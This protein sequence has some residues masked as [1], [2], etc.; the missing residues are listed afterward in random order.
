MITFTC[1]QCQTPLTIPDHAAGKTTVCPKCQQPVQIPAAPPAPLP[2]APLPV[3]NRQRTALFVLWLALGI[4]CAVALLLGIV[5]GLA[6][7]S[8][9][10]FVSEAEA[11]QTL[12]TIRH[13]RDL[14]FLSLVVLAGY[15]ALRAVERMMTQ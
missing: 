7:G 1:T 14:L 4:V 2:L 6:G 13:I 10:G 5:L 12:H 11:R 15:V 8:G 3:A 9:A